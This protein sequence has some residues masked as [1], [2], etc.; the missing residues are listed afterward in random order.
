MLCSLASID[1]LAIYSPPVQGTFQDAQRLPQQNPNPGLV[2]PDFILNFVFDID[3]PDFDLFN[4]LDGLTMCGGEPMNIQG[5]KTAMG[6]PPGARV[7]GVGHRRALFADS[8]VPQYVCEAGEVPV[9]TSAEINC[10]A[11]SCKVSKKATFCNIFAETYK[12]NGNSALVFVCAQV[13]VRA[14]VHMCV[15]EYAGRQAEPSAA[16]H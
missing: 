2:I 6:Y 14:C 7:A 15:C 4:I 3:F 16:H 9:T 11:E 8:R 5:A 1:P 12:N 13:C 10:P